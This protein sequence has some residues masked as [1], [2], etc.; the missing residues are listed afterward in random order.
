MSLKGVQV[1]TKYFSFDR[2]ENSPTIPEPFERKNRNGWIDW[3]KDNLYPMYLIKLTQRSA[4]HNAIICLKASMI[5]KNGFKNA[6]WSPETISFI[7]NANNADDNLEEIYS[8]VAIDYTIFK[9][10]ALELIWN[11]EKTKIATV[12]HIPFESIRIAASDEGKPLKQYYIS[13][14]WNNTKKHEPILCGAFDTNNRQSGSQILYVT[15]YTPG[16]SVYPV[17]E[18]VAGI[19]LCEL[20]AEINTFHLATVKNQFAPSQHINI[21]YKPNSDEELEDLVTRLKEQYQGTKNAGN[22]IITFSENGEKT[23]INSLT[24]NDSD[25]RFKELTTWMRDGIFSAHQITDQSLLGIETA[26]RLGGRNNL[27]EALSVF[28]AQYVSVKQKFLEDKLN[29]IGRIN[30]LRDKLQL[31]K[32][33]INLAPDLPLSDLI[34]LLTSAL[35]DKQKVGA[36]MYK[37]FSMN[38]ALELVESGDNSTTIVEPKNNNPI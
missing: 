15:D 2:N 16:G 14:D 36:L 6:E 17:P 28:Q 27:L 12:N 32:Y 34:A 18:Y 35:T 31:E 11:K 38:K 26:G 8:K 23:E 22:V 7:N 9:G 4:I 30:G 13:G 29:T 10:Y 21:P 1:N 24:Q 3:G 19:T 5:G 20:N 25:K 37:G 33:S